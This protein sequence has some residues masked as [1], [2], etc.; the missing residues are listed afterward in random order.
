MISKSVFAEMDKNEDGKVTF[1]EFRTACLGYDELS[2]M[3]SRKVI[4]MFFDED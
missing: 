2:K 3:L 1:E 4:D